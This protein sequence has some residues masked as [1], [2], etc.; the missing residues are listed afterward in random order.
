MRSL[1]IDHPTRASRPLR[2]VFVGLAAGS[3]LATA[4][5]RLTAS[6]LYEVAPGNPFILAGSAICLMTVGTLATWM[7]AR[8]AARIVPARVLREA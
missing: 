1:T 2:R 5:A 4:I 3:A 6:V 7:P 8:R